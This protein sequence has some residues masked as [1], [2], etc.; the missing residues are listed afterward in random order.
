MKTSHVQGQDKLG[1]SHSFHS[2]SSDLEFDFSDNERTEAFSEIQDAQVDACDSPCY[3][4]EDVSG[5]ELSNAESSD[6]FEGQH[7]ETDSDD[8]AE[9]SFHDLEMSSSEEEEGE[10][11]KTTRLSTISNSVVKLIIMFLMF[12]KTMHNI[13]DSAI[14]LLFAFS[15][16]VIELLAK[17]SQSKAIKDIANLLPNSLY[18][19]R[20]YLGIKREDFQKYVVCPRCSAIYKPEDCVQTLA[21]GRKKGKRCSF[22][23]FPDHL[24]RTQR[25]PCGTSLFKAVR[26]KNGDLILKAKRVF[27][28]RPV[29]KTLEEF[30]KRP[31]FGEKCEEFKK[32]PRDPELLGDIYDGRIWKNFK[33]AE[34]E[35][36]FDS[37][38]TFGCMLNLD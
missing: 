29:K 36:F 31:G 14:S 10:T 12:W 6:S 25:K 38:N 15:K 20:N 35:P 3:S 9:L 23:E 1:G 2:D 22:V 18:M 26:S 28:Y 17:I 5:G 4:G 34:G 7:G 11:T 8:G 13:S 32:E 37:P 27:C 33:N 19:I 30:L 16:K 21:N 24:R